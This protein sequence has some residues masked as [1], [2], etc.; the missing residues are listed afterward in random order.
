MTRLVRS[1]G[2]EKAVDEHTVPRA[3]RIPTAFLEHDG[4]MIAG[5]GSLLTPIIGHGE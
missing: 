3:W 5:S 2:L 4:G 1:S